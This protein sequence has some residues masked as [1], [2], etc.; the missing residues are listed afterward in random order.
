MVSGEGSADSCWK[1][2]E[3]IREDEDRREIK[4]EQFPNYGGRIEHEDVTSG[5]RGLRIDVVE[6]P[7]AEFIVVEIAKP[8]SR[9]RRLE[10]VQKTSISRNW[11]KNLRESCFIC[12]GDEDAA[13]GRE[14]RMFT[15][16]RAC[17]SHGGC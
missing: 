7:Q 2:Q 17:L 12:G 15:C 8:P 13:Y 4:R 1:E 9:C 10:S 11:F 6:V 16:T 3:T 5:E 14:L